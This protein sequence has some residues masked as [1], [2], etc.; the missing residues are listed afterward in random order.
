[1]DALIKAAE[2]AVGECMGVRS[3]ESVLIITDEPK[4]RIGR[5]LWQAARDMHTEAMIVEMIPRTMN[6]EEPPLAIAELMK[7]VDAILAP[8]S[9]SLS[10][11]EARRNACARGA[12]VATLPGITEEVMI[13]TLNADYRRIAERSERIAA[14][15]NG[16]DRVRVITGKGTDVTLSISG[17]RTA[18]DTGLIHRPGDF[19]NLPAGEAFV[20]PVEGT[21]NGVIVVDGTMVGGGRLETPI[22]LAVQ[23]GIVTEISGGAE[24][25]M[26]RHMVAPY[27]E[28]GRNVAELGIGTN[29]KAMLT[30]VVLEDEKVFGTVHMA[31]GDNA[32][33]GGSVHVPVHIDG[34]ML[35]PTLVVDGRIV[36]K[37]GQVVL[38]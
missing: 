7:Q 14:L 29:D 30:G 32:S 35:H 12:R 33:M 10:H 38:E 1:M 18:A 22:R 25:E 15:L 24:A 21:T 16:A 13:R 20:A 27:G 4:R 17:R 34:V 8:T 36:L 31:L 5:A 28:A 9:V 23:D 3:G 26:L 6:G 19:G 37:D 2:I 11:T